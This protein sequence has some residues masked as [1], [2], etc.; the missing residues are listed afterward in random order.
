MY[1]DDKAPAEILAALGVDPAAILGKGGESWVYGLDERRVARISRKDA[2]PGIV[3]DRVGLLRELA[4]SAE[5]LPFAIPEVLSNDVI[6]GHCVSV[7]RRIPGVSMDYALAETSGHERDRLI[8]RYMEASPLIGDLRLERDGFG[9]AI[10]SDRPRHSGFPSW[11]LGAAAA[12]LRTAGPDFDGIDAEALTRD[13]DLSGPASVVHFDF[14]PGN[15]IV[16]GGAVSGVIDFGTL[17]LVGDRR[18]DPLS[19][20]AYLDEPISPTATDRDRTIAADWLA[21][22]GLGDR[23]GPARRWLAAF[24]S[25][26]LDDPRLVRWSAD[27]LLT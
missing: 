19:A 22:H 6:D 20:A 15:V 12:N 10:P 2:D 1:A 26:A 21:S 11:L 18:F 16:D 13:L 14:F 25:A 27:V 24:W 8:E 9:E 4:A 17:T 23:L 3:A 7:E 5:E